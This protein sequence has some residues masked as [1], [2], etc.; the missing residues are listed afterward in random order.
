MLLLPLYQKKTNT[1]ASNL[2]K[3]YIWL[4]DTIHR[5]GQIG[6]AHV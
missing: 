4:A 1:M 6:R 3:R 2:F 5:Y